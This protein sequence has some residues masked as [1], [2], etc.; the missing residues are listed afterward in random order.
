MS[1]VK[2]QLAL[3]TLDGSHAIELARITAPFIDIIEAGTPLIKSEGIN[4]V[5]LLKEKHPDKLIVAD[6]KSSDVGAYE[7]R[8]AFG[9]GADIVTTQ[10]ITTLATIF[11]VQKE[12]DKWGRRAEVD[13]TGVSDPVSRT[14]EVKAGGV[15]LILFHRSIDEELTMGA[16]WDDRACNIVRELCKMDLDVAIAGGVGETVMPLFTNTPLYAVIVG[17]SITAQ[18]DPAEAART[19]AYKA[20]QIW[21]G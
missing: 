19:I 14:I 9:A 13:M 21:P 5:R 12:A 16:L 10:G 8:M 2:I 3:D 15:N 17:R 18:K 7:A 6:L 1:S 4:I 20:K 11:E